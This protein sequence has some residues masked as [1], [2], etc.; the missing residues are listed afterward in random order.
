AARTLYQQIAD[1]LQ[2]KHVTKLIAIGPKLMS[3]QH[4]FDG[5]ITEKS[6][7]L[8]TEDFLRNFHSSRCRNEAILIKGAR[9]FAFERIFSKLD[10]KA[11]QTVMEINLS[12]VLHNLRQYQQLLQ[13]NTKL[14]VMVKAFSYGSGS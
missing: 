2:H 13:P 9:R 11:H 8:T 14:M 1:L 6:F 3:Y 4:L 10:A 5:S 7:Y 12:S